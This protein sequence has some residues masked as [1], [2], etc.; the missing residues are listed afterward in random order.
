MVG[1]SSSSG[2]RSVR[3]GVTPWTSFLGA[4]GTNA[5]SVV[6]LRTGR[7]SDGPEFGLAHYFWAGPHIEYFIAI[8][9]V[10]VFCSTWDSHTL[11]LRVAFGLLSVAKP[12]I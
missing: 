12:E 1:E 7:S 9:V 6:S 5:L 8:S 3:G 11:L 4:I 2:L 10:F